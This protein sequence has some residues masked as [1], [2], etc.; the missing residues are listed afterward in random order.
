MA[1]VVN[2]LKQQ[3]AA[4]HTHIHKGPQGVINQID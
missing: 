2:V 4:R 1:G 3:A